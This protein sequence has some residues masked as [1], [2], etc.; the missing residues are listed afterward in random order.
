VT[1]D[2]VVSIEEV[3]TGDHT[4]EMIFVGSNY[5]RID[6]CNNGG[7]KIKALINEIDHEPTTQRIEDDTSHS[8]SKITFELLTMIF[9][10]KN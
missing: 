7:L 6:I 1:Y 9:F 8:E 3:G 4:E 5:R 10:F 2:G